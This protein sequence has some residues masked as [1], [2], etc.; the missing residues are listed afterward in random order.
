MFTNTKT[1]AVNIQPQ[2][3]NTIKSL[4]MKS[5]NWLEFYSGIQKK[6]KKPCY[7]W[8]ANSCWSST[9]TAQSWNNKKNNKKLRIIYSCQPS[10]T[11]R[12]TNLY[13][14]CSPETFLELPRIFHQSHQSFQS[15]QLSRLICWVE[16]SQK[17]EHDI[18][19]TLPKVWRSQYENCWSFYCPCYFFPLFAVLC[20]SV[21]HGTSI[22]HNWSLCFCQ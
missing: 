7:Y 15:C 4:Q 10:L 17:S 21:P 11:A 19:K 14:I 8:G 9:K 6:K 20:F 3:S 1:L 12:K 5:V 18:K 16:V 13:Q 22:D 2:S